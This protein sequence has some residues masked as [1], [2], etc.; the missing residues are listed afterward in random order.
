MSENKEILQ[1]SL[2]P[3]V[4][5][6]LDEA[7]NDG[8]DREDAAEGSGRDREKVLKSLQAMVAAGKTMADQAPRPGVFRTKREGRGITIDRDNAYED[9]ET[10]LRREREIEVYQSYLMKRVLS[11][12]V[13]GVN[14]H[15]NGNTRKLD[16]AVQV[17]ADSYLVLIP[18]H[19]FTDTDFEALCMRERELDPSRTVEQTTAKYLQNRLNAEVDFIITEIEPEYI[20]RGVL[21]VG[22]DR[23][24][25][26]YRQ[27]V[28]HWF[29]TNRT[30]GDYQLQ[31]GSKVE[32][33]I[34]M[35]AM[36]GVRVEIFGVETFIPAQEL[37]YTF[38]QDART[39]FEVGQRKWVVLTSINRDPDN[40]FAVE[41]TASIKSA[42]PDPREKGLAIYI[43]GS[44]FVGT[45]NFINLP[46]PDRPNVRPAVYVKLPHEGVQVSC[47]L[48]SG[49]VNP[50]VGAT[51]TVT[52]TNRNLRTKLLY[53][54]INHIIPK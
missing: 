52:I 29:G 41:Y 12:Q 7:V 28:Y 34:V 37:D 25:A 16:Y 1:E 48:P 19:K 23:L 22:G 2:P 44:V 10:V 43:E 53:G 8:T 27:R 15:Y 18:A 5:I 24:D 38:I 9:P 46:T 30:T 11:G 21:K 26:M 49:P 47:P 13:I 32:A 33:R 14:K 4:P 42:K 50:T 45:I 20:S 54:K 35:T 51:C 17:K 36:K 39:E 6:P 31:V 40:N 3:D